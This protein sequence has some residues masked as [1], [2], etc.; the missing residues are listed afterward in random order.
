MSNAL[1][2]LQEHAPVAADAVCRRYVQPHSRNGLHGASKSH[3][4]DASPHNPPRPKIRKFYRLRDP[5]E[6]LPRDDHEASLFLLFF[7][8]T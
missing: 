1:P 4:R 6:S 3:S 8:G 5:W 7:K 2:A